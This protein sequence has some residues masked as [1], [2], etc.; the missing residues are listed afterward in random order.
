MRIAPTLLALGA[1]AVPKCPLCA[2]ALFS[3]LGIEL[4]SFAPVTLA[5]VA[6]PPLMIWRRSRIAFAIATFGAAV[7]LLGMKTPLLFHGGVL[8]IV[9]ASLAGASRKRECR[10]CAD[11]PETEIVRPAS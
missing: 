1:L 11:G 3:A 10:D 6:V 9:G 2:I 8:M 5:L 7:A 4:H